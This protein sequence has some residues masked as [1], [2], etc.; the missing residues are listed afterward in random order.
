MSTI[1]TEV[2]KADGRK[3]PFD[4]NKLNKWGEYAAKRSVSWSEMVMDTV[5]QLYNGCTTKEIHQAMINACVNKKDEKHLK[6]AA[7]LL[8]GS[9]YKSVYGKSTPDTFEV[10]YSKLVRDGFWQDFD[11]STEEMKLIEDAFD[12]SY[13]KEYEY[14]SLSQFIDK[15]A[16]SRFV[17]GVKV[18]VETPQVALMGIALALF[19]KDSLEHTIKFYNIIK[20]RKINIA[21]PI[22]AAARTGFNEFTSCFLSTCGDTLESIRTGMGLSYTMTANRSGVGFEFDIR[23]VGDIVGNNKCLHAGKLPH[24]K[25]LLSTIKSVTQGVRGGA[26]TVTFNVLDPELD[27]LLR[28]KNP[29][30]SLNKR[31]ELMD[32]SL[33]WNNDF[34]KRV[35]KNDKWLLISKKDA[36]DLHKAFYEDRSNFP[37]LMGKYLKL[38]DGQNSVENLLDPEYTPNNV[39]TFNGK[40]VNARDVMK[41][42]LVQRQETGRM[43]CINVDTA[44]DHSPYEQDIVRISNLCQETLLPTRGF[45]DDSSLN[46]VVSEDDGLVGLCFLLATDVG[47]CSIGDIEEVNFYACRALD[48]IISMTHYPYKTLEDVGKNYRSIGVGITNLAYLMAKEG[49]SYASEE[50][51]NFVHQVSERHQY[52]LYKAS[53]RLAKERGKFGWYDRTKYAKGLLCIDTY[54][55]AIDDYHSQGLLCDWDTLREDISKYGL[56]FSTH[57]AMMP[58]ES[59]SAWGYSA[60]SVYPI[61][62]GV[63]VKSRPEGLVPFFAPEW[64]KYEKAYDIAWD[65]APQDLY[66]DYGIIQ[67]FT[68][69]GISADSY[70]DFSKEGGKVSV[71]S[72]MKDMLFS[73][74]VGMK[75]HYYLNQRTED[76]HTKEE[77]SS[78]CDS[79]SL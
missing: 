18:P 2:V 31:I 69:Q 59:S 27:D 60:N 74:K 36:P 72:M 20:Q 41:T 71:M 66:K 48:N 49:L 1:I 70:L 6:V 33:A 12:P 51:R 21:T 45:T 26:S 39:A 78:D 40:V 3:V 79:C 37:T 29:T 15:Y 58:V 64:S 11:L 63:L 14:T 53:V 46:K 55:K 10:T 16:L 8:R 38:Y 28:L 23:S 13:D 77:K 25:M 34:L 62:A 68:C 44:N 75:T 17:G 19:K 73:Q 24:Y 42:F 32:Y 67:K 57:S 50:G 43:Y 65:I 7:R 56:R 47:K 5:D 9:L 22:M 52:Y 76:K 54:T 30:T 4:A 35:A 61:R